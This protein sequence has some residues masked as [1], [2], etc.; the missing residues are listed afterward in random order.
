MPTYLLGDVL[1]IFAGDETPGEMDGQEVSQGMWL[2]IASI[3]MVPVAM[4]VL[5][6]ALPYPAIQWVSIA[7][8][9][10]AVVFNVVGL[11][12]QSLFDNVLIGMSFV[13]NGLV[14]SYAWTWV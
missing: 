4:V 7:V 10:V 3:M 11:P 12:Y 9:V 6:L 2:A 1:R 14:V 13:L 8:A 5:S